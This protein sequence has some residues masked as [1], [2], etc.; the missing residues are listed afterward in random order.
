MV[1]NK[2]ITEQEA[3]DAYNTNLTYYGHLETNNSN[4]IMYYQSAVMEELESIETIP[5]SILETG[6]LKIYTYLDMDAQLELENNINE[7]ITNEEIEVA[8]VMMNPNN[9]GII[10]LIGGKNYKDSQFNRAIQAKR[11]V[12]STIKPFLY[13]TALENGFTASTLSLKHI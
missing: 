1:K 2:Y 9:G 7:Y 4:T 11:Q 12:G 10:A 6:G 5:K 13:Y 8:S 3:D